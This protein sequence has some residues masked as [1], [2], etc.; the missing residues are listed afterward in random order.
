MR[1]FALAALPLATSGTVQAQGTPTPS[2]IDLFSGFQINEFL[3]NPGGGDADT[4]AEFFE[5]IVT[6]PLLDFSGDPFGS[7]NFG[8]LSI[9][10]DGLGAG[11]ID[12]FLTLSF[13]NP[14]TS[15]DAGLVLVQGS[16]PPAPQPAVA[17]STVVV[18]PIGTN[19]EAGDF[20]VENGSNTLV[21]VGGFSATDSSTFLGLD[22][23]AN[24][25]GVIDAALPFSAVYDSISVVDN[26]FVT[27]VDPVQPDIGYAAQFGGVTFTGA[28]EEQSGE[29]ITG[30]TR[31]DDG[32]LIAF[33]ASGDPDTAVP[34]F[35]DGP[36]GTPFEGFE[37][38]AVVTSGG[39]E[40]A[41]FT[42]DTDTL[43]TPGNPNNITL[44]AEGSG[45]VLDEPET[46]DF[47]PPPPARS[48]PEG[49]LTTV[50]ET[51][52]QV[53]TVGA[54]EVVI[55]EFLGN[56]PGGEPETNLIE[57]LGTPNTTFEGFLVSIDFDGGTPTELNDLDPV[58][59]TFD[60][61]G[62][63]VA[64]ID[65]LENPSFFLILT[66]DA[67]ET[68]AAE[69]DTGPSPDPDG[70]ILATNFDFDAILSAP[71]P[72]A[73]LVAAGG[74]GTILDGVAVSDGAADD[75][76]FDAAVFDNV[77]NLTFTDIIGDLPSDEPVNI[78]R[79]SVTGEFFQGTFGPDG[80]DL[81]GDGEAGD[82]G[83]FFVSADGETVLFNE[84]LLGFNFFAES[85]GFVNPFFSG[86][87]ESLFGDLDG[88]L[89]VDVVDL[90]L[91]AASL[92][93]GGSDLLGDL[94]ENG[95]VDVSDLD[96]FAGAL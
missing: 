52:E 41:N 73:A 2:G 85:F 43:L 56:P 96:L 48:I 76:A 33:T 50:D 13:A 32:T 65:D 81:D 94:D 71:D 4:G 59:V 12:N 74:F 21:L 9:E 14:A 51:A 90:D 60:E 28:F 80:P 26:D 15:T 69:S 1:A 79:D 23:D 86:L 37:T 68:L 17:S 89:D 49:L 55:N 67:D 29:A 54:G 61:N 66:S 64:E 46:P 22:I 45:V 77:T 31:A 36:T 63:A 3:F 24:N 57:L 62:I 35:D 70:N 20:F 16:P 88:D 38:A 6:D 83:F 47:V 11:I 42:S 27:S 19:P 93:S 44:P 82:E 34:T 78:F 72:T 53:F 75:D 25:D 58:N 87:I 18:N 92:L 7:N 5:L 40:V 84:D 39:L 91:F 8:L 30:V 10:G 95:V